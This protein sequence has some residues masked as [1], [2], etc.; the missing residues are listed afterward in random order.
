MRLPSWRVSF[1]Q[2]NVDRLEGREVRVQWFT[3]VSGLI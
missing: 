1:V 2:I 3:S